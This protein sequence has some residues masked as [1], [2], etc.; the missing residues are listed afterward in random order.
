MGQIGETSRKLKSQDMER[1]SRGEVP[2]EAKSAQSLQGGRRLRGMSKEGAPGKPLISVVTVVYNGAS[3]IERAMRS[4]LQQT[5]EPVEYIIIDGGSEDGTVEKIRMYEDRI[6]YWVSEADGGIYDA[7]NK[8]IGLATGEIV[9]LL[10]A[11]DYYLPETCSRV[12]GRY[13]ETRADILFG[14]VR[15]VHGETGVTDAVVSVE[16]HGMPGPCVSAMSTPPALWPG[17]CMRSCA[18]IPN[19]PMRQTMILWC[20]PSSKDA[21]LPKLKGC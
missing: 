14:D 15:R 2:L 13:L 7:M 9:G 17:G 4:V 20:Q 5:Y 12:A 3:W 19:M 8:G 11:D 18:I 6:D 10:N 1:G 16:C 21:P